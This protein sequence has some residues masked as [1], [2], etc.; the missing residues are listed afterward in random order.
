MTHSKMTLILI[1][2]LLFISMLLS[3]E[4]GKTLHDAIKKGNLEEVK[5]ILDRNPGL[6]NIPGEDEEGNT[7]ILQAGFSNKMDIF[8]YLVEK[9]ADINLANKE[10]LVPLHLAAFLGD[11]EMVRLLLSKGVPVDPVSTIIK[12][13]PLNLAARLG[14]KE[15]VEILLS[16]D[17][18]VHLKGF[19]GSTP[20]H[21]AVESRSVEIARLLLE[22]GAS[23]DEK[24]RKGCT[25]L[26]L[27]A[28]YGH[29][30]L[31]ATLLE[32]GANVNIKNDL[33]NPPVKIS[34]RE[35]YREIT[36]ML[37]AKGATPEDAK[38][39][40][41]T[42]EYLGQNKPGLT[43][44]MFAP[45]IVST[46]KA[47]LNSVFTPDGTEFYYSIQVGFLQWKIMVMKRVNNRWQPPVTA[48]FSGQY[49]DVDIFISPDGKKLFF[50]S[51]RPLEGTGTPGKNFDIW[52]LDRVKDGWSKP[53][54]LGSPVNSEGRDFYAT[55]T[56][57]GT[58]YFQSN[59]PESKGEQDIFFSRPVNGKYEKVE[60]A[61]PVIN[62][63]RFEGDALISPDE[64]F[65][66]VTRERPEG[67]GL[68]DLYIS[69]R[70]KMGQW[71]PLKNM[72]KAVNTNLNEQCPILSPDGK[73]LFFTRSN[74]IFWVDAS[75]IADLQ[76]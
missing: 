24:D 64:N 53:R 27:A 36:D 3:G 62:S 26:L 9:G 57:D 30:D 5:T 74:D 20:L 43:A 31:V 48:P 15:V 67:F 71:T 13:T 76:K 58:L 35:G 41:L 44:E 6:L 65:I 34:V 23:P 21:S 59:R 69:F 25:P 49:S 8:K 51:N 63:E 75:I 42:G 72:G 33:G 11:K 55:V 10:G 19:E 17:A 66:I 47:E 28:L 46:E 37:I 7:P 56:K 32:K 38:P 70:D 39:V 22:K 68:S 52:V 61:G 50:S 1:L 54:N 73:Y 45:N 4:T 40:I 12:A 16:A 60:N 2:V 18:N 14:H 29:K